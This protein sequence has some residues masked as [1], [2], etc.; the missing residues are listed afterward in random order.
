[1]GDHLRFPVL[2]QRRSIRLVSAALT[3][4]LFGGAF[5]A[6]AVPIEITSGFLSVSDLSAIPF[7]SL[8]GQD[9]LHG[10]PGGDSGFVPSTFCSPCTTGSIVELSSFFSGSSLAGNTTLNGVE[11][12]VP[13]IDRSG[14]LNFTAPSIAVPASD[15]SLL[16]LTELFT[17][18]GALSLPGGVNVDMTGQGLATLKLSGFD[19]PGTGRLYSFDEVR[20]DFQPVPEPGTLLMLGPALLGLGLLRSWRRSA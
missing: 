17:F 10:G 20:Y 6:F 8:E 19:Q 2:L 7:Y 11:Y 5:P 9:F 13:S 12:F 4:A 18:S 3:C 15:L 1:V 14:F 16:I